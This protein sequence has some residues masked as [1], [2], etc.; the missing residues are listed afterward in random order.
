MAV[1]QG[2]VLNPL[3]PVASTIL[4]QQRHADK[5]CFSSSARPF[6]PLPTLR[7]PLYVPPL[8]RY[9]Q[10]P[11]SGASEAP[12][13]TREE[14]L[15]QA[16]NSISAF[17]EKA[18]RDAGPSTVK[19]RKL[20]RQVRLRVELP[21]LNESDAT[22]ASL[23]S[24]LLSTLTVGKR[25]TPVSFSVF[26]SAGVVEQLK[27]E[28]CFNAGLQEGGNPRF[29]CYDFAA[30]NVALDH[31][32]VMVILAPKLSDISYI[33][34]IAKARDPFPILL[35]NPDWSTEEEDADASHASLLQ[36]F[37]VIYSYL[38]LTIQ[39]FLSKTEGAVLKSVKSGAP[40]GRPWLVFAKEGESMKCVASLKKR[41]T[42]IDL[43][44]AL[45]NA[46]A[47]NSPVTKSIQFLRG[48]VGKS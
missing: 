43:E 25:G 41:P 17:V 26:S 45:Y 36:S 5:L 44:N 39:G 33:A 9:Q 29:R 20:Y 28:P 27:K 15:S 42:A 40:A 47:A 12:P 31:A 34:N 24:D 16:R 37:E 14:T 48:L 23:F 11:A 18:L 3:L 2:S 4:Q 35:L 8:C 13:S 22:S 7:P 19:Q 1:L 46:M 30:E 32:Q 10:A 38:P 21:L 6:S